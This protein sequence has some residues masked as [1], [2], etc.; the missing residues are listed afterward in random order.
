ML[1]LEISDRHKQALILFDDIPEARPEKEADAS[2]AENE[3]DE[4]P[5]KVHTEE[6]DEATGASI[7]IE[8]FTDEELLGQYR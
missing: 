5:A 1:G 3:N 7:L 2:V 6:I 4:S 8:D